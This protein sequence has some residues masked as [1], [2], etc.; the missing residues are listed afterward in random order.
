MKGGG[1]DPPIWRH[2]VAPSCRA[3][4][5]S[6]RRTVSRVPGSPLESCRRT[7][8]ASSR[9]SSEHEWD[10]STWGGGMGGRR[11]VRGVFSL[12]A[13]LLTA[14]GPGGGGRGQGGV[15]GD[16][17]PLPDNWRAVRDAGGGWDGGGPKLTATDNGGGGEGMY[18]VWG[19]GG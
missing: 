1:F 5:S 15:W 10:V 4:L 19:G 18:G 7:L 12:F 8:A 2:R 11:G 17:R 14:K 13:P 9:P 6:R 3:P 16:F